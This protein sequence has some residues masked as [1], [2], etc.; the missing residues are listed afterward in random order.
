[1]EY[2][3]KLAERL[4]HLKKVSCL[5]EQTRSLVAEHGVD[6]YDPDGH[7]PEQSTKIMNI[8]LTRR[9]SDKQTAYGQ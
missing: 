9:E 5:H 6:R 1:V 4:I 8:E 2:V 3:F 7:G